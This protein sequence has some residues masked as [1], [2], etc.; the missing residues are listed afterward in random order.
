M[1][2][3]P[4]AYGLARELACVAESTRIVVLGVPEDDYDVISC[5]ELGVAGFVPREASA[6]ELIAAIESAARGE[7]RCSPRIVGV[8][9]R[10]IA[11]LS[12]ER[13]AV[14]QQAELTARE[15]QIHELLGQGLSNKMISR[16]LGIELATVKNHVHSVLAKLGVRRR[17]QVASLAHRRSGV[18]AAPMPESGLDPSVRTQRRRG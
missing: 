4:Q 6:V 13:R 14:G 5:A 3:R 11:A 16:K 7:V 17:A 9:F 10:R 2:A 15:A 12:R 1:S 8:L 18:A